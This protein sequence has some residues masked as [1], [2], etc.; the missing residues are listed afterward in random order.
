MITS[1]KFIEI[2]A[3]YGLMSSWAIWSDQTTKKIKSGM[4]DIS[5]FE[6]PTN[7]ILNTLNPNIVL[8][9][10]NIS[11]PTP[12][13]FENFHPKHITA[14]DYKNRYALKDTMFWGAYMHIN[15]CFTT[16]RFDGN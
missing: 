2:K 4:E 6:N 5:F 7:S 9:G 13:I 12:E 16:Y 3:E 15:Y 10:L 11:R 1:Q 8:V 14:H